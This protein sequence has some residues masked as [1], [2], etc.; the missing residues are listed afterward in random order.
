V[1]TWLERDLPVLQYLAEHPPE[2]GLLFANWDQTEPDERMPEL[3]QAA[4]HRAVVTLHDDRLVT[5]E[6][7][8]SET[9]GGV[10]WTRF[11]VTGEGMQA[12]GE[13]PMFEALGQPLRLAALLETLAKNAASDEEQA[14]LESAASRVRGLAPELLRSVVVGALQSLARQAGL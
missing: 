9:G 10:H 1:K 13:W 4:F 3:S 8:G 2:G 12:L 6:K 11:Q 5:W 7:A 14:N